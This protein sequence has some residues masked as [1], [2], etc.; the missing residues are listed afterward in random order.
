MYYVINLLI[1][2]HIIVKILMQ[3]HFE[4]TSMFE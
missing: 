3:R 4:E 1:G 2:Y